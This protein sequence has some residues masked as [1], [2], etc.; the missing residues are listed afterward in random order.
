[1]E[2]NTI[3][4]QIEINGFRGI[5]FLKWN[6]SDGLNIILGGGDSG[7]TTILEAISLLFY[8]S[9]HLIL[10]ESDY[11]LRNYSNGFSIEAVVKLSNSTEISQQ[12]KLNWPWEWNGA[13]AVIPSLDEKDVLENSLEEA[14]YKFRVTGTPELELIWEILQ[15]D[16]TATHL[17]VGIRRNI[18]IVQLNSDE[19]SDRDLRLVYGSAL[20]KLL[21]DKGLRARVGQEIVNINI[22]ESLDPDGKI[23]LNSLDKLFKEEALPNTLKLGLI[24]KQGVSI[25][26]LVGL[27]AEK[28]NVQLPLISWGAGTRRMATLGIASSSETNSRIYVI[29]ELER[30][31]EP[32][33]QRRLIRS[34][35]DDGKQTFLTTHSPVVIGAS[36][37][38]LLW[39]LDSNG[40]LG[41]LKQSKIKAQQKRDPE[42]FLSKISVIAEGPT[43]V[44]FVSYLLEKAF[45]CNPLDFG[46]RVSDGQGN[47][48]V[49]N[50]L[51]A[52][53]DAGLKFSGIADNENRSEGRWKKLK[54]KMKEHLLQWRIGCVEEN[55][56]NNID[57][58]K[59]SELI[60]NSEGEMD[61][62]RLRTLAHRLNL[63]EKDLSEIKS[64]TDNFRDLIIA[65]AIGKKDGAPTGKE[66]DW[67]K[68]SQKWFKSEEGGRELAMK[69]V[70]LGAWPYLHDD[71]L[72][73]INSILRAIGEKE[74]IK[75]EL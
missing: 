3:I 38:S 69:M 19:R 62:D 66:K 54:I 65:A 13:D 26:A 70:S 47:D 72:P 8:P 50:L 28:E 31:L 59:L 34:L 12:Q 53:S 43:E 27:L 21:S 41:E 55:V 60:K 58:K 4:R 44:G 49:L 61:G 5:K 51:E 9:N 1:M 56:I 6:P 46:V 22:E 32:Y 23:A 14:V 57:E 2:S 68:H 74:L 15:P 35:E 73:F 11:W 71:L 39:Y 36:L 17:S 45:D 30:G 40:Q 67:K 37:N 42:T 29:D 20:D 7:K 75:L 64:S 16:D 18:G 48:Q 33:R 52:M 24:S 10:S 63:K 25:G